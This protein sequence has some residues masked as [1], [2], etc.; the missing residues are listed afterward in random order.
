MEPLVAERN[1]HRIDKAPKGIG[2]LLSR[3]GLVSTISPAW[4]YQADGGRWLAGDAEV[5]PTHYCEIPP[6][7]DGD[8]K[9]SS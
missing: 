1:W 6:S 9:P 3:A 5:S 2:P 7:D 8:G 4:E